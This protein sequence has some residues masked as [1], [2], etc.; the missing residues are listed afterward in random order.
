MKLQHLALAGCTL[1]LGLLA[2]SFAGGSPSE[3]AKATLPAAAEVTAAGPTETAAPVQAPT[4]IP[5]LAGMPPQSNAAEVRPP[6]RRD[7]LTRLSALLDFQLTGLHGAVLGQIIDYIVNTCET[8]VIYAVVEPAADLNFKPGSL[9]MIPFEAATI[10]SGILDAEARTLALSLAPG[11]LTA[12]PVF[13]APLTLYPIE[14]EASVRAYWRQ[15]VRVGALHSECRA[16]NSTAAN[17]VHKIGYAREL[18]A[19][20]IKDGNQ[21]VLGTVREAILV[22]ESGKLGF[23]VVE[24][25]GSGELVLLPLGKSNIPEA[26]LQPG[27]T[28]ELVLLA[29]NNQLLQA[30]RLASLEE[31]A[32]ASTQ[33][34]ARQ[35]WGQ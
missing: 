20:E 26:A 33:N 23:Y 4:L 25:A 35:Y 16:G 8:Y 11:N 12:A 31:A 5:T 6:E 3:R 13:P 30:P 27:S 22:P 24:L 34:T 21:N 18:L 1:A 17:A 32:S 2:C 29:D 15:V 7:E 9:L 10:N 28:L 14:W 19:A